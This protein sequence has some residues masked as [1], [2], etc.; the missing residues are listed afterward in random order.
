MTKVFVVRS[1]DRNA[2]EELSYFNQGSR[3]NQD[4]KNEDIG[5]NSQQF[6]QQKQKSQSIIS[7]SFSDQ[8]KNGATTDPAGLISEP[9]ETE[10][11]MRNE[12]P[13]AGNPINVTID[14]HLDMNTSL[15]SE[16]FRN[17][18]DA[19]R[20]KDVFKAIILNRHTEYFGLEGF[21]YTLGII[22]FGVLPTVFFSL[23][24]AHNLI[25]HPQF[26]YEI[27][28]H[29]CVI[30]TTCCVWF[31]YTTGC[32]LN[33]N[34]PQNMRNI[35]K[36][37]LIGNMVAALLITCTYLIWTILLSYQYPIPLFGYFIF[38]VKFVAEVIVLWFLFPLEWRQNNIFKK[39]MKYM[40]LSIVLFYGMAIPYAIVTEIL[41][42]NQNQ[43]QPAIALALPIMR[44]MIIWI[45]T[46]LLKRSANGDLRGAN[47]V[48]TY[49]ATVQHTVMI[50]YAMGSIL[51]DTTSVVLM[52]IDFFT[53]I[54]LALRIVWLRKRT[55]ERM[56]DA[57]S[58]IEDLVVTE[59]AEFQAPLAFLLTFVI[60]WFGPNS[61]LFGNIGNSYWRFEAT[62]DIKGSVVNMI[63][64]F[65]ID[66]ASAI[67]SAIILQISCKINLLAATFSMQKKFGALFSTTLSIVVVTV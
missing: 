18:E 24:P 36:F 3:N 22:T 28:F 4:R 13:V 51:T 19:S 8:G 26:W 63:T 49:E 15:E 58:T 66:F 60:T 6:S 1:N 12:L 56:D 45:G 54:Y 50:C 21:L 38:N 44:E 61:E 14:S 32:F 41:K 67:L 57:I 59:L 2:V 46:K 27:L 29:F 65:A 42:E 39:R 9:Q 10:I 64:F 55:T 20:R 33:T 37:G 62:E 30:E 16:K 25:T 52:S 40:I 34:H 43:Y 5:A 48:F 47:I 31:S 23:I 17:E 7:Y 35:M 11:N 53:N